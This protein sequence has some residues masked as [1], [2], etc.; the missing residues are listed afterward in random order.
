MFATIV[1]N[2]VE[3]QTMT[4]NQKSIQKRRIAEA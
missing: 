1:A 3:D 2:F 4:L